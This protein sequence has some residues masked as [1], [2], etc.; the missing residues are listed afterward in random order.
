VKRVGIAVVVLAILVA[1]VPWAIGWR[2]EQLVRARVTQVD[3]DMAAK[4]RLRIDRYQRG[5]RGSNALFIVTEPDGGVLVML[6]ASIRH[7]PFAS[8]G[9]ADWT[10]VPE[11]GT[12]A[13]EALGPWGE[14]LPEL[15]TYTRLSWGGDVHTRIDSPAF[16]RRVPEVAGGTLEV[17]AIAGTFDWKR[18]GALRYELALPVFRVERL[19]GSTATATD[20][21]EF[22]DAVLKGDGFLGTPERHWNQKGSLAAGS[23]SATEAGVTILTATKPTLTYA[24]RDEGDFVAM[25]FAFA[26]ASVNARN[27]VQTLSDAG[28]EFSFEAKHL[29][30]EPL[31]RLLDARAGAAAGRAPAGAPSQLEDTTYEL[32]R[33]SPATD[34]R[35]ALQARE[36]RAEVK[37]AATFDG[38][39]LEPKAGFDNWL[40]RLTAELNAR[41]STPLVVAATRKGTDAVAG[42]LRPPPRKND[43]LVLPET[44]SIDPDAAVRKQ[45]NEAAA[46]G[47]IRFEG[48]E[49]VTV[50]RWS[51]G[52]LTINGNDMSALRDLARAFAGR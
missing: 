15:T 5:W 45:L 12:T 20:I 21:I 13:R 52:L 37:L 50:V 17:A 34:M 31:G 9:P 39:G 30:K 14:K 51:N 46:Q 18:D 4:V 38:L 8:D 44:P 19:G 48:D 11:L 32:M 10:A 36:G 22:K 16:K 24:S 6:N 23:F 33:G 43:A 27:T 42:M 3:N 2:T 26:M 35:F 41:A 25:Q 29:A 47:L 7:W 1:A 28:V 49:V 40:R